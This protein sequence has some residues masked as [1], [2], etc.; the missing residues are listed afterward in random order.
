VLQAFLETTDFYSG[1]AD[2]GLMINGLWPDLKNQV[3]VVTMRI[4]GRQYPQSTERTRGP[5]SLTPGLRQKSIRVADRILRVRFDFASAPCYAR[6][7]NTQFD[8][9]QIGGR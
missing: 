5:W 2:G 4:F 6:G 8:I 1:N 9:Q 3:G 7:G